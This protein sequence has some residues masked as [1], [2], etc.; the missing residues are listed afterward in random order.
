MED[1]DPQDRIPV[2]LY[3]RDSGNSEDSITAQL[4][5][6]KEYAGNSSTA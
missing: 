6:Q 1:T 2:A 4:E 5:V 3:V